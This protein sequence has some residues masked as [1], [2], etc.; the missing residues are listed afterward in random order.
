MLLATEVPTLSKYLR[1]A[2]NGRIL[3]SPAFVEPT[4]RFFCLSQLD[5]LFLVAIVTLWS[6]DAPTRLGP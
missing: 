1:E 5:I 2:A 6:E 4:L 3:D